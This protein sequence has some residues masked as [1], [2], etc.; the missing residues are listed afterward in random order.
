MQMRDLI[1][2]VE[3]VIET[4]RADIFL[5]PAP[6]E[7][8]RFRI[9]LAGSIDMGKAIDWQSRISLKLKDY[10][11]AICNP[12]RDDWDS[13]WE[14]DISNEKFSEQVRWELDNLDAADLIVV[15]FDPK[16]QAPITLMELGLHAASHSDRMIVCCPEGFWRRGNVQIV[17]DRFGIP[18]VDDLDDLIT[19]TI[20]H[21]T[22]Q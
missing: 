9:F 21:L 7:T 3:T 15:Y 5:P 20:N 1:N 16:G 22:G 12:R 6:V 10:A 13:T 17:C 14:Q 18:M 19:G 4:G 2:I 11:V 8:D